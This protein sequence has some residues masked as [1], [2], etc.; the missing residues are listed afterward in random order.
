M[1]TTVK[2][3]INNYAK[4]LMLVHSLKNTV[5]FDKGQRH[6]GMHPQLPGAR[7]GVSSTI[8]RQ[9]F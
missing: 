3:A 1:R 4:I 5:T 9:A 2:F 8:D 7:V 6:A